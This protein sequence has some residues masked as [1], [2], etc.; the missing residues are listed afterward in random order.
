L[1]AR[2][3]FRTD[4]GHA[5]G[6]VVL[7]SALCDVG[8]FLVLRHV[9]GAKAGTSYLVFALPMQVFMPF[10]FDLLPV[11]LAVAGVG[12]AERRR[13]R[14]GG[15]LLALAILAKVWPVALLPALLIMRRRTAVTTCILVTGAGTVA[16]LTLTGLGGP[17][18]L[19]SFRGATGWQVEST[20][21]VLVWL[22]SSSE[23]RFELSA[24]RVGTSAVWETMLLGL[25]ALVVVIACWLRHPLG[26]GERACGD[27]VRCLL[28][29][30]REP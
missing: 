22:L 2:T 14:A 21:G 20:I 12:L 9:W 28:E 26:D 18:Q 30:D 6:R 13:E 25:A 8:V 4:L 11:L 24:M 23:P 16:W 19:V 17:E 5:V 29:R 3:L 10:R 7:L 1:I 15:A 27:C